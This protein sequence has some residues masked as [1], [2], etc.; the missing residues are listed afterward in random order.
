M[1]TLSALLA[2]CAGDLPFTGE[3]SLQNPVMQNF[4]VFLDL[5][6]YKRLSKQSRYSWF[7][8]KKTLQIWVFDVVFRR[9]H[10]YH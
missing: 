3:L 7:G 10:N 8:E 1:G 4:D 2:L 6:Q 9:A 5:Q